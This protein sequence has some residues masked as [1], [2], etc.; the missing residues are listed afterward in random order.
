VR[1]SEWIGVDWDRVLHRCDPRSSRTVGPH[2]ESVGL[3]GKAPDAKAWDAAV[4]AYARARLELGSDFDLNDP[5]IHHIGPWRDAVRHLRAT[6]QEVPV[7]R[8]T[9]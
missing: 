5:T 1:S 8:L 3:K 4:A 6:E 9:G 7:L 2:L